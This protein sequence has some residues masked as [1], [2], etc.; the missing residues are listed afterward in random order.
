[1]YGARLT[2]FELF[3]F[4]VQVD[5]S[6]LFL[7]LLVTWSL[8]E[9][10]F[11]ELYPALSKSDHWWMGIAGAIGLFGSLI[12]HELSH[13]LVARRF[14]LRIR[15]ITL[16]IFGGVAELE[17]EPLTPRAEFFMAAAGPVAS[18]FLALAFWAASGLARAAEA[19]L[20]AVA[21][22]DYL[23]T[24]NGLLAAFNLIPAFPLDGGR[25]LRA[26]LWHWRGDL[27]FATHW[28][29]RI[30]L[31]FGTLLQIAALFQLLAGNFVLA[32]WW[33]LIG[34]FL[35]GA[36]N[37]AYYQMFA[38]QAF[39]GEPVA[40]FMSAS[41][42]TVPPRISIAELVEDYILRY[43]YD[44]FPVA[45]G[46]RLIGCVSTRQIKGLARAEWPLRRVDAIMDPCSHDNMIDAG[47]DASA[48]LGQMRRTGN[49]RLMVTRAGKLVGIVALKDMLG[50]LSLKMDLDARG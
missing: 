7:A 11:P 28:A 14:D 32:M 43:Q 42:V 4:K 24:I 22:G 50:F 44:L 47:A 25:V 12:F 18:L 29:S 20:P 35:R 3:G 9:G 23:A 38:R 21:V 30:G 39:A 45:D 48:A 31:G 10:Y 13:S 36:A 6:W 26:A 33:F 37:A 19:P 49:S 16:F 15:G 5:A 8:A 34:L 2:L 40:R 46:E 17:D 1:M 41:P 27:R